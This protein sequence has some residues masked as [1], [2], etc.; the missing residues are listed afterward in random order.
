MEFAICISKAGKKL[1]EVDVRYQAFTY[2]I[3]LILGT[4]GKTE[5][6]QWRKFSLERLSDISRVTDKKKGLFRPLNFTLLDLML[7]L[8]INTIPVGKTYGIT[9]YPN[10]SFYF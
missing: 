10:E 3:A 2:S 8:D 6:S 7:K 1:E 4:E 9:F 5:H